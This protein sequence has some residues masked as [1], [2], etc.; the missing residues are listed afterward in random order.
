MFAIA[1]EAYSEVKLEIS[2]SK[3]YAE[4]VVEQRLESLVVVVCKLTGSGKIKNKLLCKFSIELQAGS[5]TCNK[6]LTVNGDALEGRQDLLC[7]EHCKNVLTLALSFDSLLGGFGN[8]DVNL[9]RNS[10]DLL[11]SSFFLLRSSILCGSIDGLNNSRKNIVNN[12]LNLVN[13]LVLS[14]NI[15]EFLGIVCTA[16][17]C[18]YRNLNSYV[19]STVSNVVNLVLNFFLLFGI[20]ENFFDCRLQILRIVGFGKSNSKVIGNHSFKE[21]DIRS[22]ETAE[23]CRCNSVVT[24]ERID[25]KGCRIIRIVSCLLNSEYA[26]HYVTHSNR[27]NVLKKIIERLFVYT[28]SVNESEIIRVLRT[29]QDFKSCRGIAIRS[30]IFDGIPVRNVLFIN[31]GICCRIRRCCKCSNCNDAEQ[32]NRHEKKSNSYFEF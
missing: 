17:I 19:P 14:L 10:L 7:T 2:K 24:C 5:D 8:R 6:L 13:Y 9:T 30:G 26:L 23:G 32:H 22:G 12:R 29:D 31:I 11:L 27:L 4:I 3:L 18:I 25:K 1:L 15:L 28:G 20:V 16:N 21:F